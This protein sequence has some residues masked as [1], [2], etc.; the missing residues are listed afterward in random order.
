[1][2]AWNYRRGETIRFIPFKRITLCLPFIKW[3]MILLLNIFPMHYHFYVLNVNISFLDFKMWTLCVINC[4][5]CIY[6]LVC[7]K[8]VSKYLPLKRGTYSNK[9]CPTVMVLIQNLN[10]F[11]KDKFQPTEILIHVSLNYQDSII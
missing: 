3:V 6:E 9:I 1:M 4:G 11:A 10:V 7:E 5:Y 8:S 2:L